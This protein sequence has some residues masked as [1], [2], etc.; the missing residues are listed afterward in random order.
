MWKGNPY[1]A[2]HIIAPLATA[3]RV[4]ISDK[5]RRGRGYVL[6]RRL[7][8]VDR[9]LHPPRIDPTQAGSIFDPVSS[10]WT[11][12]TSPQAAE[13]AGREPRIQL[14]HNGRPRRLRT[15]VVPLE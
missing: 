14:S 7:R 4:K 2:Y 10:I 15:V 13:G 6:K 5:A 9:L 11:H 1:H 8:F 12:P 3:V